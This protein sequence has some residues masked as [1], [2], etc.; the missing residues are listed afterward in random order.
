[1]EC[2]KSKYDSCYSSNSELETG[3]EDI[4]FSVDKRLKIDKSVGSTYMSI[5]SCPI[6]V[7]DTAPGIPMKADEIANKS[8]QTSKM[9]AVVMVM[10]IYCKKI[11]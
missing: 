9:T 10:S 5:D 8:A 7:I 11:N 3:W 6:K 4:N 1:M 2:R